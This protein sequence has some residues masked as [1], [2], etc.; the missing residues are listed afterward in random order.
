MLK[1]WALAPVWEGHMD[2]IRSQRKGWALCRTSTDKPRRE[3]GK[4]L[5]LLDSG[6]STGCPQLGL[7]A[8]ASLPPVQPEST[9]LT[10][11]SNGWDPVNTHHSFAY[12]K[13]SL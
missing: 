9:E 4:Q 2:Q 8:V 1:G 10:A 12:F 7:A 5:A 11:L 3:I 13:G 6:F